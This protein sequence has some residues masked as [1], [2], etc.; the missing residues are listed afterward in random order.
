MATV[1]EE[2]R[3]KG[4]KIVYHSE[5]MLRAIEFAVVPSSEAEFA[6]MLA[7]HHAVDVARAALNRMSGGKHSRRK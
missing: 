3:I 2:G 1:T 6:E 4:G 5:R 7:H